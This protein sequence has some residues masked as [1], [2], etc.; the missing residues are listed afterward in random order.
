M[1]IIVSVNNIFQIKIEY[2]VYNWRDTM[3]VQLICYSK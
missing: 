1:N 3:I 2:E